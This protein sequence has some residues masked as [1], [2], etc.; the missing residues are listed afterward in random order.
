[1]AEDH[2]EYVVYEQ[3]GNDGD[4]TEINIHRQ[5]DIAIQECKDR[6]AKDGRFYEVEYLWVE[7]GRFGVGNSAG[8]EIIDAEYPYYIG[9]RPDMVEHERGNFVTDSENF[10]ICT[11]K[12]SQDC[13]FP[14]AAN[15]GETA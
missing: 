7:G 10:T 15:T 8:R 2:A 9:A 4:I 11:G 5:E 6:H 1:M 12:C 14:G 3:N 13:R